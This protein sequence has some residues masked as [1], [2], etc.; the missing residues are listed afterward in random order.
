MG[1]DFELDLAHLH[2]PIGIWVPGMDLAPRRIDTP[3]SLVDLMP[4]LAALAGVGHLNTTMGQ[5]LLDPALDPERSI[6][7]LVDDGPMHRVGLMDR[8]F[9]FT[10]DA[11]GGRPVLH[12]LTAND[13]T[14]DASP[15]HAD[16]AARMRA[17]ALGCY[18]TSQYMLRNNPPRPHQPITVSA[19]SAGA[20][21]SP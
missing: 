15:T 19:G 8:H 12:D 16:Q 20:A 17:E 2:V 9:L 7:M 14:V 11:N 21:G 18:Q 5:N 3:V 6:F 1:Q 4:T 10:I 13:V